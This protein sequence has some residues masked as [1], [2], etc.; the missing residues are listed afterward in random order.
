MD[1]SVCHKIE[2]LGILLFDYCLWN[3]NN[4]NWILIFSKVSNFLRN[5]KENIGQ[6]NHEAKDRKKE[7]SDYTDV[8]LLFSLDSKVNSKKLKENLTNSNVYVSTKFY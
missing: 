4:Y 6:H 3:V 2:D 1:L 5:I 8:D 7:K